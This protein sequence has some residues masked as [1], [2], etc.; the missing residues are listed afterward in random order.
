LKNF[1]R[2]SLSSKEEMD[3]FIRESGSELIMS[4]SDIAAL[5]ELKKKTE[6]PEDL[7]A[8]DKNAER[9]EY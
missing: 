4:D 7:E 3:K 6:K 2:K 1:D 8:K 5:S 9:G